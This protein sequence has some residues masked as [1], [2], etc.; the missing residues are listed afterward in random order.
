MLWAQHLEIIFTSFLVLKTG[1]II[2]AT[3]ETLRFCLFCFNRNEFYW[4][5]S[6]AQS[7]LTLCNTMDCSLPHSSVHGIFQVRILEWVA[8]SFS[9]GIFLTQGLTVHL[10]YCKW[11]LYHWAPGKPLLSWG[12]VFKR[13][14]EDWQNM[15]PPNTLLWHMNF[16]QANRGERYQEEVARIHRKTI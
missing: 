14:I 12:G 2:C 4:V 7:C 16:F 13:Q 1:F 8:I 5:C 11:T 15:L 9:R 6:V 3:H 10:L